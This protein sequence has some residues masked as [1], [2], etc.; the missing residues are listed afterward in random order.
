MTESTDDHAAHKL[1]AR[2]HEHG[3]STTEA[4]EALGFA[5][6]DVARARERLLRLRLFNPQTE[7]TVD[8]A[9]ALA[10][11]LESHHRALDQLLEQHVMTA[12]LV[13]DYLSVAA[14]RGDDVRV[15]FYAR[16]R[17][18]A[19]HQRIDE[20]AAMVK[21]EVIAMHPPAK[22]TREGLE[23]ALAHSRGNLGRGVRIRSIHA[24]SM[25]NDPLIR[26]FF[27]VWLAAGIE[28]RVTPVVPTRMLIY[29]RQ[30]AIVQSEPGDPAGGAVLIRGALLVRSLTALFETLWTSASEP[31]DVP[32]AASGDALTGQQTAVL[33]LL[34]T[35]AK[36]EAIA[37]TLGV[38]TRTVTRIV[39][40]LT[41]LLGAGSR[42]QAGARAARLGWLD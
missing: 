7:T 5:A 8:S 39:G 4:A 37:R 42:F 17:L 16:D 14:R 26:E 23:A 32:R 29:D 11:S 33:R 22:W 12:S 28:V 13:K 10:R 38:S 40:E 24:Q 20:C 18:A 27:Q 30:V 19:L 35:G 2:M 9:V 6:A 25:V 21:H 34:A 1:Y 31:Q 41:A 15:E 36:D 3:E